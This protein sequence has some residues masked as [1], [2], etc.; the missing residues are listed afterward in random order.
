MFILHCPRRVELCGAD[1]LRG[2]R[3]VVELLKVQR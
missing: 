3:A 1:G 2:K